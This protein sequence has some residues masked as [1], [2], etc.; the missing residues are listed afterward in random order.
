MYGYLSSLLAS[1]HT[2][3]QTPPALDR[4]PLCSPLYGGMQGK[5]LVTSCLSL[6][7]HTREP[8]GSRVLAPNAR[9]G[10]LQLF[11]GL[12]PAYQDPI[13]VLTVKCVPSQRPRDGCAWTPSLP[14][15]EASRCPLLDLV[16]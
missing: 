15:R 2:Q 5:G 9:R 14:V 3:P 7:S 11:Q 13:L 16:D 8:P 6:S 1:S 10:H 12:S 4:I